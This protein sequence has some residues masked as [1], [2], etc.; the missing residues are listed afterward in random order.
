MYTQNMKKFSTTALMTAA[1][2]TL[3]AGPAFAES[4][5]TTSATVVTTSPTLSISAIFRFNNNLALGSVGED[6]QKLQAFLN[7][8]AATMVAAAPRAGS[9]GHE[10]S[11]FGPSTMLAVK[12]YQK[13]HHIEPTGIVGPLTRASIN[14]EIGASHI[15]L[16]TI[17]SVTADTTTP[18]SAIITTKYDG[19][20]EKPTVWFAY[21]ATP[22][23]MTILSK[24]IASDKIVGTSQVTISNLGTGDCY[25]QAFVKNSVG[26]THSDAVHCTK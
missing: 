7:K 8:N 17:I 24:E 26:T 15:A 10:T 16:P 18:G 12:A 6:T 11:A 22:S 5:S 3:M 21:G 13:A 23:S 1:A 4:V 14:E 25:A 9:A 19:S 20:G 2:F